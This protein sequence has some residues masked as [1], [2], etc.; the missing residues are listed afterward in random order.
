MT[1]QLET[2]VP[3][4]LAQGKVSTPA[5]L[6]LYTATWSRQIPPRDGLGDDAATPRAVRQTAFGIDVLHLTLL[7]PDLSP[8]PIVEDGVRRGGMSLTPRPSAAARAAH[9][10]VAR[11]GGFHRGVMIHYTSHP[12]PGFLELSPRHWVNGD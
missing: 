2:L 9:A 5:A 10:A 6:L 3:A 11:A 4:Q 7:D 1:S 12:G 8:I